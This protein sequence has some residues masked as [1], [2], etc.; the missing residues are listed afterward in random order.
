MITLQILSVPSNMLS[1][2]EL[3]HRKAFVPFKVFQNV[4]AEVKELWSGLVLLGIQLE[5]RW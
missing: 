2:R 1:I 5:I 4:W 3:I